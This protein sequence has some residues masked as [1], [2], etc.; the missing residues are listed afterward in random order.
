MLLRQMSEQ[1]NRVS[2]SSETLIK[3]SNKIMY[4]DESFNSEMLDSQ[5]SA[6]N[7]RQSMQ[8]YFQSKHE[9][10]KKASQQ[11]M[12]TKQASFPEKSAFNVSF[13]SLDDLGKFKKYHV[14]SI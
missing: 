6:E 5:H 8:K 3:I 13:L 2:G 7:L 1:V 14:Q 4:T 9:H 11:Y 10:L 12:E